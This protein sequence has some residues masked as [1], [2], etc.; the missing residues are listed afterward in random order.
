MD[1]DYYA[2]GAFAET[3]SAFQRIA[4]IFSDDSYM[5]LASVLAMGS[6]LVA[7]F[8][9]VAKGMSGSQVNPVGFFVPLLAGLAIFIGG[10]VP[11]STVFVFDPV[12]NDNLAVPGVPNLIVF[13]AGT[14]N[15]FERLIVEI[16][17]TASAT[18]YGDTAGPI[19]FNLLLNSTRAEITDVNIQRSLASYYEDCG[20]FALQT[21]LNGVTHQELRRNT[22]D[23]KDTFQKFVHDG[24]YTT[25]YPPGGGQGQAVSCRV[26]WEGP[27]GND[28]LLASIESALTFAD[29]Q[30]QI[31]RKAGFDPNQAVQANRCDEEIG[32]AMNLY[33][34]GAAGSEVFLRSVTLAKAVAETLQNEEYSPGQSQ[35]VNRQIMAEGFGSATAMNEWIPKVRGFML[36]FAL[37]I[38]V[39]TCLFIMTPIVGRA[40][41]LIAGLFGWL[42]IWGI[43]DA[44]AS[45]MAFDAAANAF[46]EMS[47]YRMGI[48]SFLATPEAS[49]KALG[50]YGKARGTAMMMATVISAALFK[51]GGYAFTQVANNWQSHLDQAGERAG[52]QS[53]L[54]EERAALLSSLM[55]APGVEGVLAQ[56]GFGNA[57]YGAAQGRMAS[58][59]SAEQTI[60][61]SMGSGQSAHSTVSGMGRTEAASRIGQHRGRE[62]AGTRHGTTAE[63]TSEASARHDSGMATTGSLAEK[64]QLSLMPN[65]SLS[66]AEFRGAMKGAETEAF[67]G[68]YDRI[69]GTEVAA[70]RDNITPDGLLNTGNFMQAQSQGMASASKGDVAAVTQNYE[71]AGLKAIA[72]GE[73]LANN[74]GAAEHIGATGELRSLVGSDAYRN[75]NDVLGR[76]LMTQGEEVGHAMRAETARAL[77]DGT[78]RYAMARELTQQSIGSQIADLDQTRML[79]GIL[80][81]ESNSPSEIA[82]VK[83][84]QS[85]TGLHLPVTESNIEQLMPRLEAAGLSADGASELR[86]AGAGMITFT[87]DPAT[88]EIT[89]LQAQTGASLSDNNLVSTTSGFTQSNLNTY[90]A[91]SSTSVKSGYSAEN[92]VSVSAGANLFEGEFLESQVTRSYDGDK[93]IITTNSGDLMSLGNSVGEYL[94]GQGVTVTASQGHAYIDSNGASGNLG[95][96]N[97]MAGIMG[98]LG[99]FRSLTDQDR[100]SAEASINGNLLVGAAIVHDARIEAVNEFADKIGYES[101]FQLAA[102]GLGP[103]GFDAALAE[104]GYTRDQFDSEVAG[105]QAEIIEQKTGRALYNLTQTTGDARDKAGLPD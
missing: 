44:I 88:N 97:S 20:T 89:S 32:A 78:D 85:S 21:G 35:L 102:E 51:F 23:L 77:D 96:G 95:V 80:G 79:A 12:K 38:V 93:E 10:V 6:I 52:R 31:C 17:D 29:M 70:G 83:L 68:V 57:A 84:A 71:Q 3:V 34:V 43:T 103:T 56:N 9:L 82:G 11:K 49:V 48:D 105:R 60:S 53:A 91:D 42:M 101:G 61:S 62:D 87:I 100:T 28:G 24:I 46:D 94:S 22:A 76:N 47:R 67:L 50:I 15:K 58:V 72:A 81:V 27:A 99:I 66:A 26:A 4:L 74:N 40:L 14:L 16:V 8:M 59:A 54:P 86:E 104:K 75:A 73:F 25:F 13:V 33:G 1:M 37:G 5:M 18:A 98:Q 19:T 69:N 30:S 45:Q 65:G 63:E 64:G 41:A 55:G 92:A 7:T 2:Y 90:T 36:A 39:V